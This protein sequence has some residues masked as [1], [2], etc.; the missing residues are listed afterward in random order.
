MSIVFISFKGLNYGIDF[1]G[2]TLIELRT[3]T[4]I[5]DSSIRDSLKTMNLGDINVKRFGKDGDFLI[6]VEQKNNE[7]SLIPKIKKTLTDNL[8]ADID[9]R[10]R[11][12]RPKS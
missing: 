11:E 9:F 8:N 7:N 4:S 3:E 2:G 12:C 6:K 10:S 5:N 1:K